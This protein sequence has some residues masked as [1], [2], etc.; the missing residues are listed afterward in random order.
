MTRQED[1]Q[2]GS[3]ALH[4]DGKIGWREGRTRKHPRPRK[5]RH[6][7]GSALQHPD[8]A[9]GW[10]VHP[11]VGPPP[12]YGHDAGHKSTVTNVVAIRFNSCDASLQS[13]PLTVIDC[14]MVVGWTTSKRQ[15]RYQI[16]LRL[17][18][19]CSTD[20]SRRAPRRSRSGRGRRSPGGPARHRPRSSRCSSS[21]VSARPGK[22]RRAG[23]LV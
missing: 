3:N 23:D 20:P 4:T 8:R 17:R 19:I 16:M 21:P 9:L 7:S 11:A 1:G 5:R 18:V 13:C 10:C 12:T 14:A 2:V 6:S 15:V 22:I